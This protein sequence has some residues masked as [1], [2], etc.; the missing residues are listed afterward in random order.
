MVQAR[1]AARCSGSPTAKHDSTQSISRAEAEEPRHVELPAIYLKALL[2]EQE[3]C[4][5]M[6]E[7]MVIYALGMIN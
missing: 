1:D 6:C 3:E 5:S 4:V 7:F 2:Y